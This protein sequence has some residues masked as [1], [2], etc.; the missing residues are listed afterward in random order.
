GN[1]PILYGRRLAFALAAGFL[2]ICGLQMASLGVLYVSQHKQEESWRQQR[3]QV[4]TAMNLQK[5]MQETFKEAHQDWL[6]YLRTGDVESKVRFETN[7]ERLG[8]LLV[9]GRRLM[10]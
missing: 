5:G 2:L 1:R 4:F 9:S 7:V 6:A 3:E 10:S 8:S